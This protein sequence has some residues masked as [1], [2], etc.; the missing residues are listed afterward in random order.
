MRHD[1]YVG[2]DVVCVDASTP[3]NTTIDMGLV[4]GH[5]YKIRW[6]GMYNNYVDGEFLGV[7]LVGL[8]RGKDPTYGFDDPPFHNRRF[9][10]LNKDPLAQF[11][12]MLT[13]KDAYVPW[14]HEGPLHPDGPLPELPELEE[15]E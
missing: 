14:S 6:L 3:S 7:R 15:V 11:R 10:P 4:E 13:G 2:Q 8:A 9:M 1:L 5:V 12:N